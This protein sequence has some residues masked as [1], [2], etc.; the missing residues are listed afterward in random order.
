MAARMLHFK[1]CLRLG[2]RFCVF[3]FRRGY[4]QLGYQPA[5]CDIPLFVWGDIVKAPPTAPSGAT[6][7][8]NWS[9]RVAALDDLFGVGRIASDLV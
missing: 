2:N 1:A 6:I 4:R 9:R 8:W 5:L 7:R 3:Q